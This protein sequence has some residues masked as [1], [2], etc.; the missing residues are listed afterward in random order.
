[1]DYKLYTDY[2][3][4]EDCNILIPNLYKYFSK[5]DISQVF[6]EL[7]DIA[8]KKRFNLISRFDLYDYI[9]EDIKKVFCTNG[10]DILRI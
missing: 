2:C 4:L 9:N 8:I 10:L 3:F 6:G 5:E 7:Y 1:M